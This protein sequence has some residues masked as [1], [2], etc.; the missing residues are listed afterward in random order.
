MFRK[1]LF[2]VMGVP[3]SGTTWVQGLL[4]AHSEIYCSGEDNLNFLKLS[5]EEVVSKYN[6]FMDC[7][8]R[9]IGT[10]F[11]GFFDQE[12]LKHLFLTGMG[13]LLYREEMG[14]GVKWIGSKSP[15]I[16]KNCHLYG[17]LLPQARFIHVIRDGRDVSVSLWYNNIRV[18]E[19]DT[20]KRWKGFG[21]CVEQ[22]V[23][24]WC[25]DVANGRTFGNKN[26]G[27]YLEIR[28]EDLQ[29]NPYETIGSIF[30]FLGVDA[31]SDV[32]E[33][34]YDEA[35]FERL[36]GGRNKGLEDRCSFYRKGTVGDWKTHFDD[37]CLECFRRIGGGL[38]ADLGYD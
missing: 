25:Q 23:M 27:R 11:Y 32:I 5:L 13:L 4:N 8:N 12:K 16:I 34:C 20:R 24:E 17:Q 9:G 28:Y 33:K 21:E 36:S 3:K 10:D 38:L 35:R 37:Q 31:S 2:F 18:N 14:N 30:G 7:T 15:V 29:T 1:G 6:Y 19:A 22:S 26:G